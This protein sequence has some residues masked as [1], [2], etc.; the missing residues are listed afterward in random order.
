MAMNANAIKLGPSTPLEV[1]TPEWWAR[2]LLSRLRARDGHYK[3]LADFY[4]GDQPLAFASDKFRQTFGSRYGQLT[5]NF[6]PLV[7]DANRE[8]LIIDGFRFGP[9]PEADKGVWRIWQANQLDAE[10]LI[11]HEIALSRGVAY[12]LVAPPDRR[13]GEGP[14]VTIEDPR[15]VIVET[16]PGN[17]RIREAGLKA[18]RDE[19]GY[20]R[21]YLYLPD[22][23]YKYRS[24]QRRSVAE[25]SWESMTW[26]PF[27][28]PD[29]DWPA[30]NVLGVVPI[31]PLVNRPERDGSGQS[32]IE[33]V[34]G[35]QLAINTLRF[36]A[37]VAAEYVAF[38]Q[39]WAT[40][41]D[42]PTDEATGK[43]IAPFRPGVDN[44]WAVRRPTPDEVAEY[45]D[46]VPEAKFGQ[47]AQGDL[48]PYI[49]MIREEIM[50]MSSNSRT[51]YHYLL[52]S[53]N[54]NPPSG[55]ALKSVEAPLVSKVR[56]Q[57]IH[58]GEGWEE[59]MRV[60]LV[61]AGQTAKAA[62]SVDAETIWRDP[63]TRNEA[64]RTDAILKQY[65]AGLLPDDMALEQLGYSQQQIDRIRT[66]RV[67]AVDVPTEREN[68]ID[69]TGGADVG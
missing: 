62:R 57:A 46:K 54:S 67:P 12:T 55:E 9:K 21:V 2:R 53:Q 28:V 47:F 5:A 13:T 66:K 63:E 4:H 6:M 27:R 52:G 24:V 19:D 17:R 14:L 15:E 61:A 7:V 58:F 31:I 42:I 65:Q 3:S 64:A 45:A 20:T 49:S 39:R 10:S 18:W 26:E 34:M 22:F 32:E 41:I 40:N 44:L 23:I 33:P 50:Q 38:P 56:V 60:A 16:A 68:S 25:A 48:E 1:G 51:P 69:S 8:R 36:D 29:E 11:A 37:L 59:T 43:D 35:N 30:R